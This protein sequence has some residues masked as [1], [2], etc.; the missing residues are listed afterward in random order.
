MCLPLVYVVL[1]MLAQAA[2]DAAFSFDWPSI[3]AQGGAYPLLAWMAWEII[4]LRK[5]NAELNREAREVARSSIEALV[6]MASERK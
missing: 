2:G 3:L 1:V 6:R 5:E 4:G